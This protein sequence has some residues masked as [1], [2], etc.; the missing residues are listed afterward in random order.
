MGARERFLAFWRRWWWAVALAALAVSAG[1]LAWQALKPGSPWRYYTDGISIRRRA[2]DTVLRYVVWEEPELVPGEFNTAADTYEPCLSADGRTMVFTRGRA[3]NNADLFVCRWDGRAWGEPETLKDL[4]TPSDELGPA[5]S[6]DGRHL[7]FYSD[8]EGGLGGYDVW[9]AVWDGYAWVAPANLGTNVNSAF[10]DYGPALTPGDDRLYFSSN[11]PER[12][13]TEEE[14]QAWKATLREIVHQSD[15]DIFHVDL[16]HAPAT[17]TAALPAV[18]GASQPVRVAELNSPADEGQVVITPRGDF[19]YFSSS[20]EGG[21]GGFDIYRARMMHGA[22]L[23]PEN[24]GGP[25]NTPFNEMDPA[26]RNEGFSLVFSS[27]RDQENRFDYRLYS[28]AS[29]DVIVRHDLAKARF[30]LFSLAQVKWWLAALPFVL[31]ALMY[32]IRHLIN[33]EL[34]RKHSLLHRC[35]LVSA[36]LH[37]AALALM[38]FWIISAEM[39]RQMGEPAMEIAVDLDALARERISLDIREEITELPESPDTL[40]VEQAERRLPI[41]EIDS[42]EPSMEPV[43]AVADI[44]AFAFAE[45]VETPP[46]RPPMELHETPTERVRLEELETEKTVMRME[47]PVPRAEEDTTPQP[48]IRAPEQAAARDDT[49]VQ[50]MTPQE[51]AETKVAAAK[52]NTASMVPD[53]VAR[54][55]EVEAKDVPEPDARAKLV[56]LAAVMPELRMDAAVPPEVPPEQARAVRLTAPQAAEAQPTAPPP[57]PAAKEPTRMRPRDDISPDAIASAVPMPD[58]LPEADTASTL[59][60]SAQA[61]SNMPLIEVAA[62]VSLEMP[63]SAVMETN[64]AELRLGTV[65]SLAIP[66]LTQPDTA[67][68]PDARPVAE[69]V[70]TV[71]KADTAVEDAVV[72]EA[73]TAAP[74]LAATV[75]PA[76]AAELPQL[77]LAATASAE[78]ARRVRGEKETRSDARVAD[79]MRTGKKAQDLDPVGAPLAA[80]VRTAIEKPSIARTAVDVRAPDE[81]VLDLPELNGVGDLATRQLPSLEVGSVLKLETDQLASVPH[82]VLRQPESRGKIIDTLG[83]DKESEASVQ[84]ALDWFTK[85]QEPDGHW[86]MTKHGGEAKHEVA[87]TAMALLC[88]FGWGAKHTEAGPYQDPAKRAIQW[89]IAQ[90]K[91]NGDLRSKDM[92]DHAIATMALTEAYGITKDENLREPAEKAVDFIVKAQHKTTGGWRYQPGNPGDTSVFGWQVMALKSAEMSGI[93]VP[94]KSFEMAAKWLDKVGGGKHGG[95]Y[96]YTGKNPAPAMTAEGMFCRQLMGWSREEPKMR[97]TAAYLN[98]RLPEGVD[99]YYWY[100]GALSLFQ[101]QGPVWEEWNDRLKKKL[102]HIQVK[103]GKNAGSWDPTGTLG[104]RMGR[105]VSTAMATLSLEVYYRY[106]PL[107]GLNP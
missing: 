97:E 45:P 38:A 29:R 28:T 104:N 83:G 15:Y 48:R 7:Y 8:R 95:H 13:L 47:E 72:P 6:R 68:Q 73:E 31:L 58:A 71:A 88:Y 99:F 30:V 78:R 24:L 23:A 102:K 19:I 103:S 59:V 36:L 101:H 16:Q 57:A 77:A 1:W 46:E 10:N 62:A 34:R 33:P 60:P 107:Y 20:R 100:Y 94:A 5:L 56:E 79:T 52:V 21:L 43:V 51:L 86:E 17:N 50:P 64:A 49:R 98:T 87:A 25:V 70:V 35:L 3:R 14:K 61:Y 4:N 18:P 9:V 93:E 32:L 106:L 2:P 53:Q 89:L 22:I 40:V 39:V 76:A 92:Y 54:V 74:A 91:E 26:L 90:Q 75:V 11:R 69:K 85:T 63:P 41:P 84:R 66:V 44:S 65:E 105:V 55:E 82:Y 42:P 37:V 12:G 27:N 81:R 67:A 80:A 96:G